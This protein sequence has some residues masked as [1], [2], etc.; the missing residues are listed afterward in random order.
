MRCEH[1]DCLTCPY[2]ECVKDRVI[3]RT[4]EAKRRYNT[5]YYERNKA[6]FHEK[7]MERS[8][9]NVKRRYKTTT[10]ERI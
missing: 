10:K 7:Y 2:P 3:G 6:R 1:D 8:E 4:S 5:A 9:G